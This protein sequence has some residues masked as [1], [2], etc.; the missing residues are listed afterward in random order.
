MAAHKTQMVPEGRGVEA[1]VDEEG[2][3]LTVTRGHLVEPHFS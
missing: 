2:S 3:E 1:E